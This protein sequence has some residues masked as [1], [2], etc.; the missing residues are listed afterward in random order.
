[1]REFSTS[2]VREKIIFSFP[3]SVS[4]EAELP[5]IIRS[6]RIHLRLAQGGVEENIVVR[7]QNMP[8]TLRMAG[9]VVENFFW[10]GPVKNRDPAWERL[11]GQALSDYGK[12]YHA[13]ENWGAVYYEGAGVFQTVK[14]PFA[15][16]VER[17]AL[18]TLDNYD[19]TL[20][21]VETVL[22]RL[23][24]KTQIQHQANI[25][26]VF[27]DAEG[28]TRN[29]LIH[30]ASGQSGVFHFTASGGDRAERIGRSFLTAAAFLE[31]INLRYFIANFEAGLARG[32]AESHAD[33]MEQYKAAKKRRL[34]LMQ[35]VNG[36]ERRY[37]VNY[38][39]E[40]PD[41]F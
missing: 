7:A 25:A 36:F 38:R 14:S 33:K 8:D 12:I 24:K 10:Y 37:A 6:N 22:D 13:E 18:A 26:A 27:S 2:L 30:R 4:A 9:A 39:P 35:F 23:G 1:M 16:V 29:S 17:C 31:A 41:F 21:T 40:R 19:A 5:I 32:S 11:W 20:K 3:E 15:D 28:A 34:A